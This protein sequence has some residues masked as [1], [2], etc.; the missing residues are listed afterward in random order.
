M[1]TWNRESVAQS[2]TDTYGDVTI[3]GDVGIGTTTPASPLEIKRT[4]NY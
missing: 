4:S 3:T 1:A 2:S